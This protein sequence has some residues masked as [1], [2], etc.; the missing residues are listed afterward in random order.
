MEPDEDRISRIAYEQEKAKRAEDARRKLLDT[1]DLSQSPYNWTEVEVKPKPS[2]CID[3]PEEICIRDLIS[4]RLDD[5][6]E[7]SQRKKYSNYYASMVVD[8]TGKIT[9]IKT[10]GLSEKN[11]RRFKL[12]LTNYLS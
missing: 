11:G 3:R 7:G 6:L 9:V 10:D 4:M 8:Y 2:G 5:F 12:F 1:P